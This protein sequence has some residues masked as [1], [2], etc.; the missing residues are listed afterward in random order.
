VHSSPPE[1]VRAPSYDV[2]VSGPLDEIDEE[3]TSAERVFSSLDQALMEY[4]IPMEN[5]DIIRHA[6]TLIGAERFTGTTAYIKAH[7]RDG[8]PVLRIQSGFINGF[9]SREEA[10]AVSAEDVWPSG[11]TGVWGLT[12]P[13]HG[14]PNSGGT[15]K[16][17]ARDYGTCE[18]C[19]TKFTAAGT[20]ACS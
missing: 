12:L 6:V 4:R 2:T 13:V 5:H 14:H 19:W 16:A 10:E 11:R 8:G 17:Q 1:D 15:P 7:R 18:V 3:D 20:C 9:V